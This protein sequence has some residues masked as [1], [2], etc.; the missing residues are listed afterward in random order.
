MVFQVLGISGF[1]DLGLLG[2]RDLGL[3][4]VS[5]KLHLHFDMVFASL[6]VHFAVHEPLGI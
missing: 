2:F 3:P 6:L 5:Q 4:Q 1:R